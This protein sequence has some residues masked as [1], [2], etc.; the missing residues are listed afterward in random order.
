MIKLGVG[1]GCLF[2]VEYSG[3]QTPFQPSPTPSSAAVNR[4][5]ATQHNAE[6]EAWGARS[7]PTCWCAAGQELGT[8]RSVQGGI[9]GTRSADPQGK[10]RALGW[11]EQPSPQRV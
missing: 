7:V 9:Q 6:C 4:R 8:R 1:E 3:P 11:L 10:C 5:D 2:A